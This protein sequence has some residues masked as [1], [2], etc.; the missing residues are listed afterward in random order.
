[1]RRS[2]KHDGRGWPALGLP[3]PDK[4]TLPYLKRLET[5][6]SLSSAF[7]NTTSLAMTSLLVL[8]LVAAAA[9]TRPCPDANA[10]YPCTCTT[11]DIG[12]AI[13]LNMDCSDVTSDSRLQSVF[14]AS[15]P[16]SNFWSLTINPVISHPALTTLS[17]YVFGEVTFVHVLIDNT[18]IHTVHEEAFSA[19]H[20]TLTNLTL[21]NS[22]INEFPFETMASFL[23]LRNL[24][25]S[26]NRFPSLPN[27]ESTSLEVLDLSHNTALTFTQD[28]LK[29]TPQLRDIY[30]HNM[31][32]T[33]FPANVFSSLNRLKLVDLSNNVLKGK[34]EQAI[35]RVPLDSVEEIRLND[36]SITGIASTAITGMH[37]TA[38]VDFSNNHITAL[39]WDDWYPLLDQLTGVG[40][41]D[42]SGNPLQCSCD[43]VWLLLDEDELDK[44]TDTTTCVDGTPMKNVDIN[45]L[46]L[47]C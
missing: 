14:Q 19:S 26:N 18:Y 47:M 21:I 39:E 41:V 10:I 22:K 15:F 36:N 25:L 31:D 11:E 28:T 6:G 8:L 9:A 16:F 5:E 7:E 23:H 27:L 17:P 32:I 44:I 45:D 35:F 2:G 40:A 4:I 1:M 3:H 13:H 33:Y 30:L 34:L 29:G 24:S 42:L 20:S 43:L 37:R 46:L 38:T 12:T